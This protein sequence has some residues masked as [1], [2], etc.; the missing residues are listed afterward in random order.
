MHALNV[1]SDACP[2]ES[3]RIVRTC[4]LSKDGVLRPPRTLVRFKQPKIAH[5]NPKCYCSGLECCSRN[6]SREHYISEG[7]LRDIAGDGMVDIENLAWLPSG[8]KAKRAPHAIASKILCTSCNSA[9]SPLDFVGK[10]FQ[11]SLFRI[12]PKE[13]PKGN[14]LYLVNGHDVELWMLKVLMGMLAA[15]CFRTVGASG[16][17]HE[18]DWARWLKFLACELTLP[19]SWG[20]YLRAVP[21]DAVTTDYALHATPVHR[22]KNVDRPCGLLLRVQGFRFLLLLGDVPSDRTG[23]LLDGYIYRPKFV[24]FSDGSVRRTLSIYWEEP[25]DGLGVNVSMTPLPKVSLE[26]E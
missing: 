12:S 26:A 1:S 2:C 18:A 13:A 7:V 20:V 19:P 3:G 25:G 23:M 21:G 9:L 11:K 17:R 24:T 16:V 6:L 15:R 22:A 14:L 5:S 4:C 8:E 10:R